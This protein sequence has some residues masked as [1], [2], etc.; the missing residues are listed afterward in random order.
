MSSS[1]FKDKSKRES[2]NSENGNSDDGVDTVQ[3]LAEFDSDILQNMKMIKHLFESCDDVVIREM[4]TGDTGETIAA[5]IYIDGLVDTHRIDQL[6]G[7]FYDRAAI[8]E[9]DTQHLF[10]L[11]FKIF[12]ESASS[13]CR[14]RDICD[15]EALSKGV[16]SG[17]TAILFNGEVQ[18]LLAD[19]QSLK[20]R[21]IEEGSSQTVVRG[22]RDG[23]TET[24][25]TNISLIRRRIKDIRLKLEL[26]TIGTITKTD[27]ALMYIQ[28]LADV[29]VVKEVQTRLDRIRIDGIL[30][31][32]YIEELIQDKTFTPFPT[33]YNSERPDI[34]AA[35]LLEGRVAIMVDGTP[36][37]LLVPVLFTQFLQSPEDYYHRFDF[38]F[39]R[40]LRFFAF[41]VAILAPAFYVAISTFHQSFIPSPL[42]ISLA[43]QREGIPFPAFVE[44]LLMEITFELLREAGIRMP[45]TV[46]QS[47]SIVGALV[48]GQSAVEAGLVSPAMVIVVSF[49]AISSFL[50]PSYNLGFGIRLLRFGYMGLAA[51]FGV[52]GIVLGVVV[53]TIHLCSLRSFGIP[54]MSPWGPS[55]L[56]D[57]KDTLFRLPWWAMNTRPKLIGRNDAVRERTPEPKPD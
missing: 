42:L 8:A 51:V 21:S 17:L 55:N 1:T 45:R 9:S 53:M 11:N 38:G 2:V 14:L 30:E 25:T 19:T 18:A 54:Y 46:G 29:K 12:K 44:A 15:F 5:V 22:P 13:I 16:I 39:I 40:M 43:A 33:I 28:G 57:Q 32:G 10:R 23:F 31:S 41:F 47:I 7:R 6:V 35:G 48:L 3:T 20:D 52:Y 36:F 4:K 26:R 27:V 24:L 56:S 49:T 37:V 50:I 34:I